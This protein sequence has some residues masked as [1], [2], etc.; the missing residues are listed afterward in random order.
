MIFWAFVFLATL[1]ILPTDPYYTTP[2]TPRTFKQVEDSDYTD[3]V[4]DLAFVLDGS[5]SVTKDNWQLTLQYVTE[6]ANR[7]NIGQG[8]K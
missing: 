8:N 1:D 2:S 6:L 7:L 4:G 3:C 5:G